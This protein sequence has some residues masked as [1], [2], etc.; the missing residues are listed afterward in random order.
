MTLPSIDTWTVLIVD[1]EPHNVGV[2][3]KVLSFSGARVI[4]ARDGVEGLEVLDEITPTFVLLDLSMPNMDGWEMHRQIRVRHEIHNLPVIALTAHAMLGD[5]ERVLAEGFNGY[6]A[7]PFRIG[8][9]LDEI[10]HCLSSFSPGI[11]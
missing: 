2:A 7:K 4:T 10:Q 11:S 5:R 8:T 3:E 9:F 6:I 1:D